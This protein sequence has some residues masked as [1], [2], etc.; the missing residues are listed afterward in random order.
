MK[1]LKHE[2]NYE[3]I[4]H[5]AD[6]KV[7]AHGKTLEEAFEN[8]VIGGFDFL[9][10]T[11]KIKKKI[12]KKISL[13]AKRVESLLYDFIEELLFLLDTEGFLVAGFKDFKIKEKDERVKGNEGEKASFSLQC[14][15]LGDDYKNYKQN[16]KG[17]IKAITYSEMK[18]AKEKSGF[19]IE[20]VF[21]I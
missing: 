15:A 13:T 12:D 14:T 6:L 2:A 17:D 9:T 19:V 10:D 7:R 8:V 20:V 1:S 21:D 16:I 11:T 18:V 3:Y 5:T 4:D